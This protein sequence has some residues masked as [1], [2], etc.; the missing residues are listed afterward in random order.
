PMPMQS[1]TPAA[2][3]GEQYRNNMMA[4]CAQGHHDPKTKYGVPGII[5]A[6]VC[7]PCGL[8]FLLFDKERRCARCGERLA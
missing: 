1:M 6:I 2:N 3:V 8:L 7:F 5:G 4:Q